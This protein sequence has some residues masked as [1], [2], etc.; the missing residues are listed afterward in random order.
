[1]RILQNKDT[2]VNMWLWGTMKWAG[3]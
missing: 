3:H 2:E 1:L